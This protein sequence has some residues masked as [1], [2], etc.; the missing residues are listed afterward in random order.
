MSHT[1]SPA[2]WD[3][4]DLRDF[5]DGYR[6]R[7][8]TLSPLGGVQLW[9]DRRAAASIRKHRKELLPAKRPCWPGAAQDGRLLQ[10][11]REGPAHTASPQK[12]PLLFGGL[13][14]GVVESASG[15]GRALCLLSD[16]LRKLREGVSQLWKSNP[17]ILLAR[18]LHPRQ[19]WRSRP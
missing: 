16:D 6:K 11:L 7:K 2:V 5:Y 9:R 1:A 14:Q 12:P 18:L 3:I 4:F 19:I 10:M 17:E 8:N 15:G 13:P